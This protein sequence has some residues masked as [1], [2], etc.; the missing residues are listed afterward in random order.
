MLTTFPT[1]YSSLIALKCRCDSPHNTALRVLCDRP[2]L[3]RDTFPRM[4]FCETWATLRHCV[5]TYALACVHYSCDSV[6]LCWPQFSQSGERDVFLWTT[7][8]YVV[9]DTLGI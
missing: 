2:L 8:D 9:M 1:F 5:F 7:I 4:L 6:S 3:L